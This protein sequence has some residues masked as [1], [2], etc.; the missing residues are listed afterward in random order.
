M[1]VLKTP[2]IVGVLP[3]GL[4]GTVV[5]VYRDGAAYEVEFAKPFNTVATV[6][7][8]TIRHARA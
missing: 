1:R 5:G 6:M 2:H 3:G 7:P 8:D 4:M